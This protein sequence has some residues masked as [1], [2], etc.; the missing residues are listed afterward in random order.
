[1]VTRYDDISSRWSRQFWVKRHVFSMSF[2]NK[3]KFMCY[4]SCKAKKLQFLTVLTLFLT[5]CKIQDGDN[6]WW[7]HRPAAPPPP[8]QKLQGGVPS[9][10]P[11]LYH[12]GGMNFFY[13]W[14]T[15]H[16]L[17][18]IKLH[19]KKYQRTSTTVEHLHNGH[20]GDGRKWPLWRGDRHGEGGRGV[21][22]QFLRG[23]EEVYYAKF[24]PT[25]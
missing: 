2:N 1:M 19:N 17:S 22:W 14:E 25:L 20:L 3:S 23:E 8:Y 10:P 18:V 13:F 24:M 16:D 7:R 5:L 15:K 9:T 11:P 4:S 21:I 6:C 12:G